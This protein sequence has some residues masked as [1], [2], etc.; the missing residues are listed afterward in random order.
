MN[1]L[2]GIW[3]CQLLEQMKHP[4]LSWNILVAH[5]SCCSTKTSGSTVICAK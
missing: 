3:P 2:V 5:H 1:I 4:P